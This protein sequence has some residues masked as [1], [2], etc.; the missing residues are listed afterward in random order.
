MLEAAVHAGLEGIAFADAF[1]PGSP[2]WHAIQDFLDLGDATCVPLASPGL[3]GWRATVGER[4]RWVVANA[5]DEPQEWKVARAGTSLR[6]LDAGTFATA[7]GARDA[8]RATT[9]PAHQRVR[10]DAYAIATLDFKG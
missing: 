6:L 4:E 5:S 8:F 1:E 2:A 3:Y 10:L 9:T 7:R